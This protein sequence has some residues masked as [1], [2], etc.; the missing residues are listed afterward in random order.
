MP[1]NHLPWTSKNFTQNEDVYQ[2][3]VITRF[4][5]ANCVGRR[6][7]HH[8]T[9]VSIDNSTKVKNRDILLTATGHRDCPG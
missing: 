7:I 8:R 9:K 4:A 3:K 6:T 1:I 5:V 2:K